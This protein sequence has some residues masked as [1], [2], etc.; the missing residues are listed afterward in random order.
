MIFSFLVMFLQ[1]T[2]KNLKDSLKKCLDKKKALTQSGAAASTLPTCKYFEVMRF[3]H[4]KTSNLPTHSNL[5]IL[6]QQL[7]D[8]E[9]RQSFQCEVLPS[10]IEVCPPLPHQIVLPLFVKNL[11]QSERKEKKELTKKRSMTLL[12]RK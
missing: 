11:R 7:L 4:E 9:V 2:Y 3:L 1:K 8:C 5:D 10:P 6:D 12:S